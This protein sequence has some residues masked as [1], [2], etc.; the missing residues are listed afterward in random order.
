MAE[1][2]FILK[3]ST[4][5]SEYN[6]SFKETEELYQVLGEY[7]DKMVNEGWEWNSNYTLPKNDF[8]QNMIG[9]PVC[10]IRKSTS[11]KYTFDNKV[12]TIHK[13]QYYNEEF[14]LDKC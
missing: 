3:I 10:M 13:I 11:K 2:V 1:H 4:D 7:L 8:Y 5:I 14:K 9:F 12:I 6:I